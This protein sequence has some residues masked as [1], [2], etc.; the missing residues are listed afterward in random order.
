[1]EWSHQIFLF[2]YFRQ[3]KLT[4][5]QRQLNLYGFRR[6]TIGRD[7]GAYYHELFLRGRPALCYHM[8]RQKVKG[9]GHK[10]PADADTEPNFHSMP[11]ISNEGG[12][13]QAIASTPTEP[14]HVQVQTSSIPASP[15]LHGAAHLLR[16]FAGSGSPNF[17]LPQIPELGLNDRLDDTTATP[18]PLLMNT[19]GRQQEGDMEYKQ[20]PQ[21]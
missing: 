5:F 12:N 1:M 10:Q 21:L 14:S 8:K 16:G 3:T 20:P 7:G 15:G 2:R 6:L 11:R 9:T 13:D 4:S 17:Q 18:P 19:A